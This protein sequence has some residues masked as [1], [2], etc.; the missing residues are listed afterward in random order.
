[1]STMDTPNNGSVESDKLKEIDNTK[2]NVD[3]FI[4]NIAFCYLPEFPKKISKNFADR[5]TIVTNQLTAFFAYGTDPED[6][7]ERPSSGIRVF[8]DNSNVVHEFTES[9]AKAGLERAYNEIEEKHQDYVL[10]HPDFLDTLR[11]A[12][13]KFSPR[14]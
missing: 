1:M 14:D 5:E 13:N 8:Y 4:S 10:S 2:K 12:I 7:S 11:A 6:D 9:E 3:C